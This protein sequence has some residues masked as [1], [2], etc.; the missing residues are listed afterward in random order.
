MT[1]LGIVCYIITNERH[2]A[3]VRREHTM[4]MSTKEAVALEAICADCDEI[5]G[6]GFNRPSD[7]FV[8]VLEK[9]DDAEVANETLHSLMEKDLI[10]V[11]LIDDTLWVRPVVYARFC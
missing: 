5:D 4:S 11:D 3:Y 9:L 8:A 6:W 1:S 2:R 7:A 10:E